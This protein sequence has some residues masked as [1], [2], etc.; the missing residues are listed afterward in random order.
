MLCDFFDES[1]EYQEN[2]LLKYYRKYDFEVTLICSNVDSAFDFCSNKFRLN[3][4][5]KQ[6]CVNGA[7]IHKLGYKYLRFGN[8]LRRLEDITP[9][10]EEE[11]PDLIFVHD[12]LPNITEAAKYVTRHKTCKMILDYHAD[13][14]NSGKNWLSLNIFHKI[15]RRRFF[16]DR[17]RKHISKIFPIVPTG[18]QFLNEIYGVPFSEMELLPLGGDWDLAR[19]VEKTVDRKKLRESIGIGK[20]DFVIFTGGKLNSIKRTHLLLEALKT[21]MLSDVHLIIAGKPDSAEYETLLR[22]LAGDASRFHFLGWLSSRDVYQYMAVSDI[23]V[24]PASQSI[25]W[26]QAICMHLPLIVGD[27]GGQSLEYLNSNNSIVSLTRSKIATSEIMLAISEL[28][29]NNTRVNEMREGAARTAE[30]SLNW[31]KTIYKTLQYNRQV[32]PPK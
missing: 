31:N 11:R 19:E 5:R 32:L 20:S 9:I 16:L 30:V 18:F 8:R 15:I 23:A 27:T 13:Y 3:A 29:A 2:L 7:R 24:F 22:K 21:P 26:Q 25:L 14:S 4:P 28:R 6:Y 17:A 12:I 10:L 1:L